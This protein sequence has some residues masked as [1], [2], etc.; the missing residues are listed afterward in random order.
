[1]IEKKTD[2]I[3]ENSKLAAN[4]ERVHLFHFNQRIWRPCLINIPPYSSYLLTDI[5]IIS[6]NDS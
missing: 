4:F 5:D 1:M 3:R 2:P 6:Q